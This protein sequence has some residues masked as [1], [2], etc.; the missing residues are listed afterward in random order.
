MSS[1]SG[2]RSGSSKKSYGTPPDAAPIPQRNSP[3]PAPGRSNAGPPSSINTADMRALAQFID[4]KGEPSSGLNVAMDPR[5]T[6]TF[7]EIVSGLTRQEYGHILPSSSLRGQSAGEPQDLL[8]PVVS[9][10]S[11][12]STSSKKSYS[13]GSEVSSGSSKRSRTR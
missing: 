3:P 13:S 8:L 6:R 7:P 9:S 10:G 11:V 2:S 12:S 5:G 1:R 4:F